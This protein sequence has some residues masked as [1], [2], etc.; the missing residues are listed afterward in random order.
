[1]AVL[2]KV[3]ER[4]APRIWWD[5]GGTRNHQEIVVELASE[6]PLPIPDAEADGHPAYLWCPF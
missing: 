6:L 2:E 4:E 1:M 3:P 5:Q